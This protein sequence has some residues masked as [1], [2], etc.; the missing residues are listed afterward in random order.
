MNVAIP[1]KLQGALAPR[2]TPPPIEHSI[3]YEIYSPS[4]RK[5][6]Y[7]FHTPALARL[8][9]NIQQAWNRT[10]IYN[11]NRGNY[12]P[13]TPPPTSYGTYYSSNSY[14]YYY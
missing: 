11:Y 4:E 9:Y 6:S 10:Y 3:P 8:R 2:K 7:L 13:N 12:M 5:Y 14:Y 1:K